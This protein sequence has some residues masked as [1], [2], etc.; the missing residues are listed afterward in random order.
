MLT[1][2]KHLKLNTSV[3]KLS[4]LALE[5]LYRY[6][7]VKYHQLY[8]H[9]ERRAKGDSEADDLRVTFGPTVSFLYLLGKIHYHPKN[10]SFEYLESARRK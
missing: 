5:Y 8:T 6:R 2:H 7:S 3:L 10:D 9:L 4:A 1:P